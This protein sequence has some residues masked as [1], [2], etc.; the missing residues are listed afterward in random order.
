MKKFKVI[1]DTDPGIDD[2]NALILSFFEPKLD[3][4][5]FTISHGN[6]P[7]KNAARNMCHLLDLFG[8]NYPVVVG[9]DK[10]LSGSKEEAVHMHMV[11][12]LGGYQPPKVTITQPLKKDCADAMFEVI[13]KYPHQMLQ[14]SFLNFP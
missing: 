13:K 8:K 3:I 5:L 11:E 2:T 14:F 9:Y 4:K 10:R 12:G 7:I 6:C 1:I